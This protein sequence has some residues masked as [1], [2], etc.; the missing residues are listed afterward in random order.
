M[1]R[2]F[3]CDRVRAS[4]RYQRQ[5]ARKVLQSLCWRLLS[6]GEASVACSGPARRGRLRCM[7]VCRIWVAA[8][9]RGFLSSGIPAPA[10][11]HVMAIRSTCDESCPCSAGGLTCRTGCLQQAVGCYCLCWQ[12]TV[13]SRSG[14]QHMSSGLMSGSLQPDQHTTIGPQKL[15]VTILGCCARV[16]WQVGAQGSEQTAQQCW[17]HTVTAASLPHRLRRLL[18]DQQ[19]S[20]VDSTHLGLLDLTALIVSVNGHPFLLYL[21]G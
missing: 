6:L 12:Q 7:L 15:L 8:L 20:A 4:A 17:P 13:G 11:L 21:H 3:G 18:T 1:Q 2:R 9:R 10:D 14:T 5:P 16:L 19:I